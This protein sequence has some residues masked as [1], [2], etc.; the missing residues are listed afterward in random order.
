[1][2]MK[3]TYAIALT[4][5]MLVLGVSCTNDDFN[6][7]DQSAGKT[8][9]LKVAQAEINTRVGHSDTEPEATDGIIDVKW[10][11]GDAFALY[12]SSTPETFTTTDDGKTAYFTGDLPSGGGSFNAFFP[13]GKA[14][15][16]GNWVHNVFDVSGQ[17]QTG[18]NNLDH[19]ATYNYMTASLDEEPNENT[20]IQFTNEMAVLK[21]I[22]TLPG[23]GITPTCLTLAAQGGSPGFYIK[24][25]VTDTSL[26]E[27][28]GQVT[29]ELDNIVPD[30]N[31]KF[32]AYM[33]AIPVDDLSK[34]FEFSVTCDDGKAYIYRVK[35]SSP[36]V[37]AKGKVYASEL[38][39]ATGGDNYK[40]ASV[41]DNDIA[42]K[43]TT[44]LATVQFDGTGDA[45]SPYLISSALHL[46]KLVDD[47][48]QLET[49]EG[50][51]FKLTTDIHITADEWTPI[52]DSNNDSKKFSG[53][54][55]GDNHVISGKL[56]G[57]T[58]ALSYFGLFGYIYGTYEDR[59]KF[60]NLHITADAYSVAN[61]TCSLGGC[62]YYVDFSNCTATGNING[63]TNAG[64]I[65]GINRI[66]SF[67]NCH[68]SGN[69]QG[70]SNVGGLS[71]SF[72]GNVT[73][74]TVSGTIRSTRYNCG[75]LVGQYTSGTMSNCNNYADI[76]V[77]KTTSYFRVGGI[78][79][80]LNYDNISIT[81]CANY[82]TITVNSSYTDAFD[83]PV[84]G[85][86]GYFFNGATNIYSLT[87]N[88]STNHGNIIVNGPDMMD[89]YTFGGGL[90]GYMKDTYT[91]NSTGNSNT[92][93][94]T[95]N[96]SDKGTNWWIG[97]NRDYDPE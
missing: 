24:K 63:E 9:T 54:F 75:G 88:N 36:L 66:A 15:T 64:G 69:V 32:T 10:K 21:F 44:D 62:N 17:K 60:E 56:N 67:S 19:L 95:I 4:T 43:T 77:D 92:G 68:F 65:N 51:Y 37:Y 86:V 52:G 61:T 76:F 93:N 84:G 97:N 83:T 31:N 13:A 94:V 2:K 34:Q 50:K 47:V 82:G 81:E 90:I 5:C 74:C 29:L 55:D 59:I 28:S 1:M 42:A 41:F 57:S 89:N 3:Q 30:A 79:G 91:L 78:I 23:S 80:S 8:I 27:R 70:K 49:Y 33:M 7:N 11:S 71:Y 35:Y 6:V 87:I 38:D 40:V 96:G 46:K 85:L 58:T 48:D 39:F 45:E 18:N 25:G 72:A 20:L 53:N 16:A 22:V 14:A 12:G 73:D 26:D